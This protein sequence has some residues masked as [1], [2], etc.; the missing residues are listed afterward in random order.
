MS[1]WSKF[2]GIWRRLCYRDRFQNNLII[3]YN[4]FVTIRFIHQNFSWYFYKIKSSKC[5]W[6]FVFMPMLLL[7]YPN[8]ENRLGFCKFDTSIERILN[9]D[10]LKKYLN[11]MDFVHFLTRNTKKLSFHF[12]L[13][14]FFIS[15][16]YILNTFMLI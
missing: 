12:A 15:N 10:I 5:F 7:L 9:R 4:K 8:F 14:S 2:H 16:L 11:T 6:R 13:D 1:Q 3:Y